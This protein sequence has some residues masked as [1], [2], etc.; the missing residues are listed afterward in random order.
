MTSNNNAPMMTGEVTQG[1]HQNTQSDYTISKRPV[2]YSELP[3]CNGIDFTLN[4]LTG[5]QNRLNDTVSDVAGGY[6]AH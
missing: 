6:H 4:A 5:A 3:P 1:A 2:Q